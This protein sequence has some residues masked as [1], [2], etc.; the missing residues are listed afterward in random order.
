VGDVAVND[1]AGSV[2]F[3]VSIDSP[4]PLGVTQIA[5][6][7][8]ISDDGNNGTDPDPDNNDDDET[9]PLV[10]M[11]ELEVTKRDSLESSGV[12]V[13]PGDVL[14]YTVT[15]TSIGD[16]AAT[17]VVYA[18]TPDPN[19]ILDAGSVTTSQGTVTLGNGGGET[20][21][22]VDIGTIE[23]GNSVTLTYTVVVDP[24]LM[25]DPSIEL[26]NQGLVTSSNASDEPSDDPDSPDD[27]DPTIT[28]VTNVNPI[29]TVGQWGLL[30][31]ILLIA[32]S[33]YLRLRW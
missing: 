28:D 29:P 17:G 21:V 8:S 23:V 9:T 15:I 14:R 19:T 6:G 26:S 11:P 30:L 18:D 12:S 16:V 2:D 27:D 25:P 5:N 32:A 10:L 7:A 20:D 31:L 13:N 22:E 33:G 3:A 4:V 24:D 1:P